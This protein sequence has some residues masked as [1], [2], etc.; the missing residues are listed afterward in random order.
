MKFEETCLFA[1][2]TDNQLHALETDSFRFI[3]ATAGSGKTKTLVAL[4]LKMLLADPTLTLSQICLFTFTRKAAGEIKSR[5]ALE[6]ETI[7]ASTKCADDP[8]F[9]NRWEK[10]LGE[11]PDSFIGTIDAIIQKIINTLIA[12]GQLQDIPPGFRCIDSNSPSINFVQAEIK[13]RMLLSKEPAIKEALENLTTETQ[14]DNFFNTALELFDKYEFGDSG[15][16]AIERIVNHQNPADKILKICD[17]LNDTNLQVAQKTFQ[18]NFTLI[19]TLAEQA[20]IDYEHFQSNA[21]DF[22]EHHNEKLE[23]LKELAGILAKGLFD[24]ETNPAGF[25]FKQLREVVSTKGFIVSQKNEKLTKPGF[26]GKTKGVKANKKLGIVKVA[27]ETITISPSLYGE[28]GTEFENTNMQAFFVPIVGELKKV[29]LSLDDLK[30]GDITLQDWAYHGVVLETIFLTAAEVYK[31]FSVYTFASIQKILLDYLKAEGFKHIPGLP[32]ARVLIDE[33]QDNSEKQWE[34]AC[35]LSG[36]NYKKP[37]AWN[38]ITVVGDPEQSIYFFRNSDPMLMERVKKQ[39]LDSNPAPKGTWYDSHI[40]TNQLPTE[41]VS[42]DKEKTG[43]SVLDLNWR[44][45][46]ST[47]RLIDH[48]S[49]TTLGLNHQAFQSPDDNLMAKPSQ[50]NLRDK[51]EVVFLKPKCD[52][53]IPLSDN[54]LKQLKVETLARELQRQHNRGF[55]WKDMVVLAHSFGDIS[56]YLKKTLH[57][58]GIPFKALYKSSIWGYQEITDL[59][60]LAR[61]VS[62]E[63][64]EAALFATLRGPIGRLDDG[65]I[66]F[67]ANLGNKNIRKGLSLF[68]YFLTDSQNQEEW[69]K[70]SIERLS[71]EV[72]PELKSIARGLPEYK[73]EQIIKLSGFL[74]TQGSWRK[75]VDRCPNHTFI[76]KMVDEVDAWAAFAAVIPIRTPGENIDFAAQRIN[77]FFDLVAIFDEELKLPL[78]RLAKHLEERATNQLAENIYM[79]LGP[80]EDCVALMT[81]HG[82]KGLEAPVV[83]LIEFTEKKNKEPDQMILN[84]C[85]FKLDV[86]GNLLEEALNLPLLNLQEEQIQFNPGYSETKNG[87]SKFKSAVGRINKQIMEKES[88]RIL[89][90][91]MTRTS[92]VLIL[93]DEPEVSGQEESTT[94]RFDKVVDAWGL[95]PFKEDYNY[96]HAVHANGNKIGVVKIVRDN[97]SYS[98]TSPIG[99]NQPISYQQTLSE[100]HIWSIPVTRLIDALEPKTGSREEAVS[101]LRRGLA[102]YAGE[103]PS[104]VESSATASNLKNMGPVIGSIIHRVFEFGAVLPKSEMELLP[105]LE[106]MA[107]PLLEVREE[108]DSGNSGVGPSARIIARQV[109]T[110]ISKLEKPGFEKLKTLAQELNGAVIEKDFSMRIGSCLVYGRFDRIYPDNNPPLIVDWKTDNDTV[111]KITKTYENQMKLYALGLYLQ[112]AIGKR[113]EKIVV[114][115]G[116]T[117]SGDIIDLVYTS[118]DLESYLKELDELLNNNNRE[119]TMVENKAGSTEHEKKNAII[120]K[121]VQRD[122]RTL[123][124]FANDGDEIFVQGLIRNSEP[125][126]RSIFNCVGIMGHEDL[127]LLDTADLRWELKYKGKP[128]LIFEDRQGMG[129]VLEVC[130]DL[131]CEHIHKDFKYLMDPNIRKKVSAIIWVCD[132]RDVTLA[133]EM[134]KDYAEQLCISGKVSFVVLKPRSFFANDSNFSFDILFELKNQPQTPLDGVRKDLL[135]AAKGTELTTSN[136]AKV[137]GVSKGYLSWLQNSKGCRPALLPLLDKLGKAKK[138]NNGAH[139]YQ[140]EAVIM[141][142]DKFQNA[143]NEREC[144]QIKPIKLVKKTDGLVTASEIKKALNGKIR[145]STTIAKRMKQCIR[146]FCISKVP[147]GYSLLYLKSDVEGLF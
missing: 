65:D 20:V 54:E 146:G 115:L 15:K 24:E 147:S 18:A 9:K 72:L 32:F 7:L 135:A 105:I 128:D 114:K 95:A 89:H 27:S 117:S 71:F 91:A 5:L 124:E 23:K 103:M 129:I 21:K 66:L 110:I 58:Y 145:N 25:D 31:E 56:K 80:D 132:N 67:L 75:A 39:W 35:L 133:K 99:P 16:A 100:E 78:A 29:I 41:S 38:K 98:Y 120:K 127:K 1:E 34:L 90:V 74:G 122:T 109:L 118:A 130:F 36:G 121:P 125:F 86:P 79:E 141:F 104:S 28:E 49:S 97:S 136:I 102:M 68:P 69:M 101:F 46:A 140:V 143:V 84:P 123:R 51:T 83:A 137:L 12:H 44:T 94:S 116:L 81:A 108:D 30:I 10:I 113:P 8:L 2:L 53:G 11:I 76:K 22:D 70:P 50:E 126:Q 138:Y 52:P 144:I 37:S 55:A 131:T 43:I 92:S 59:V 139:C 88:L 3:N 96:D 119:H 73:K 19:K 64:A 42:T 82:A 112:Y 48:V 77:D 61:A 4:V 17:Q 6:V 87:F 62:D 142:V 33:F 106:S 60:Q 93:A 47:L 13:K 107:G 63:N 134:I 85:Y 111:E 45:P 57:S 26:K 14:Q 40:T